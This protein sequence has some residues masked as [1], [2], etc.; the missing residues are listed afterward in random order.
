MNISTILQLTWP[1]RA[2]Q[3][4]LEATSITHQKELKSLINRWEEGK[5]ITYSQLLDFAED[6]RFPSVVLAPPAS[7]GIFDLFAQGCGEETRTRIM[8][9]AQRALSL[10]PKSIGRYRW[11]DQLEFLETGAVRLYGTEDYAKD[12]RRIRKEYL[13]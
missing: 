9:R 3:T 7:K 5:S 8:L 12:L 4:L 11:T 10:T 2:G 13:K 1:A 6:T